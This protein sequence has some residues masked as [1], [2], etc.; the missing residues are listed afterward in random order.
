MQNALQWKHLHLHQSNWL[1]LIHHSE[2]K[3]EQE[4]AGGKQ[5]GVKRNIFETCV[6]RGLITLILL[7]FPT[8]R[9]R[10]SA[11]GPALVHC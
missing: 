2:P 4:K 9:L 1:R 11:T 8:W 10:L 3:I 5:R 6:G 7:L